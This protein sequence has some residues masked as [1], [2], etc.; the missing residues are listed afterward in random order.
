MDYKFEPENETEKT[1]HTDDQPVDGE[2]R[3]IPER[4]DAWSDAGYVPSREASAVPKNYGYGFKPEPEKKEKSKKARR[5]V[6]WAAA[7][8]LCLAP[9][10]AGE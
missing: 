3:Y 4:R 10:A 6:P 1:K 9:W 7:I 5:G 2:Y 8:A